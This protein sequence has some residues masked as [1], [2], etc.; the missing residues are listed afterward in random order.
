MS[1][2]NLA[3]ESMH[4]QVHAF[5]TVFSADGF[6]VILW[7]FFL[8]VNPADG[9]FVPGHHLSC[10]VHSLNVLPCVGRKWRCL[11]L[12]S[13]AIIPGCVII[14]SR[15]TVSVGGEK[16]QGVLFQLDLHSTSMMHVGY[17]AS[18]PSAVLFNPHN[19]P[20][21]SLPGNFNPLNPFKLGSV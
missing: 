11:S 12:Q 14:N 1:C 17:S 3:S 7:N 4:F 20:V 19:N 8:I 18:T 6:A 2:E 13:T 21:R 9:I 15:G 16:A 5:G 10:F